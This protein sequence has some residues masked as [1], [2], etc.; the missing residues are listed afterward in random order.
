MANGIIDTFIHTIEQYVTYPAEGRFQDRTSEGILQTLLEIDKKTIDDPTDYDARANL[1][2]CSTMALNGLIG[3]GVPQDWSV[4][5]IGHELTA[6]HG[7]DHAQ[8]LAVVLPAMWKVRRTQK[9]AEKLIQYA[10]RVLGI[11]DGSD[12][13]KIDKA[14]EMTEAFFNE[15][16]TKTRLS[17]YGIKETDIPKII[18]NLEKHGMTKLSEKGDVTP[19]VSELVLRTAL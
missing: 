8:S 19:D 17:D 12:D 13:E 6:L 10:E 4:H 1:V 16:G 11:T 15:L 9:K 18:A 14:I 2:L 3:S 7:L 5:M